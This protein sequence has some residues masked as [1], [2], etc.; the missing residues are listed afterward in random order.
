MNFCKVTPATPFDRNI[1]IEKYR[2]DLPKNMPAAPESSKI[3]KGL[4][5]IFKPAEP[6]N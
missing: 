3:L 2:W 1:S 6:K 5:W 4:R